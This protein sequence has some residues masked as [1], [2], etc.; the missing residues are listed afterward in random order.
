M[1]V[2]TTS[3]TLSKN[4]KVGI[5][6]LIGLGIGIFGYVL[7]SQL[8]D[9]EGFLPDTKRRVLE[10]TH[11]SH[12]IETAMEPVTVRR[13][14]LSVLGI[15]EEHTLLLKYFGTSNLRV[16]VDLIETARQL[17]VYISAHIL[18]RLVIT[19]LALI[20]PTATMNLVEHLPL[21]DWNDLVPVIFSIWATN[22]FTEALMATEQLQPPLWDLA[23]RAIIDSN[24]DKLP[25][26]EESAVLRGFSRR[27]QN[28]IRD[29]EIRDLV[30]RNPQEAW[31]TL[32]KDTV[33]NYLQE[34]PLSEI[35]NVWYIEDGFTIFDH[36]YDSRHNFDSNLL[37]NLLVEVAQFNPKEVFQHF[38]SMPRD[39]Q[40]WMLP[41]VFK[42]WAQ[43][44][45]E[46]AFGALGTVDS[47]DRSSVIWIIFQEWAHRAPGTLLE[48]LASFP[49]TER[50]NA[51]TLAISRLT[52]QSPRT[53]PEVLSALPE[54]PGVR[55]NDLKQTFVRDWAAQSPDAAYRWVTEN[56]SEGSEE[57]A[58]LLDRVLINF[59]KK[60]PNKALDIALSQAD[61]SYYV[62]NPLFIKNLISSLGT[63]GHTDLLI[64]SLERIPVEAQVSTVNKIARHLVDSGRWDEA[65]QQ[66]EKMSD[67]L[68][69]WYF[70]RLSYHGARA[71]VR[72]L[73]RRLDSLP[74]DKVRSIVVQKILASNES[75]RDLLNDQQLEHLQSLLE[76]LP[77]TE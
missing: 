63:Y 7:L 45:P 47:I 26:I 38:A 40:F 28:L 77:K 39:T 6:F 43:R 51:A 24:P 49:R 73:I 14:I 55:I 58:R 37:T 13:S 32:T 10:P 44:D 53:V 19:E 12:S 66:P 16:L 2:K 71:N 60:D 67:E 42:A 21:S 22:D 23:T 1:S 36:I 25:R 48:Q 29:G 76:Q 11:T 3:R 4:S 59:A 20:D 57:H 33:S 35:L 52:Q 31:E 54:I 65:F 75:A 69:M 15:G 56:E 41:V 46:S 62:Q 64:S 17:R 70:D 68:Q 72:E 61:T 30:V 5:I 27:L 18:R 50:D 8:F 34:V 9:S 74:S